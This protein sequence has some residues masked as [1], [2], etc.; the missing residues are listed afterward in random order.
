MYTRKRGIKNTI[1][2]EN[3]LVCVFLLVVTCM[4]F[5]DMPSQKISTW[6]FEGWFLKL[7]YIELQLK[8]QK[9]L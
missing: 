6:N 2:M 4:E 8:I 3:L 1:H 7:Y 9:K 5:P